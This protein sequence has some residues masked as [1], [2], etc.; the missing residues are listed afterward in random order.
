MSRATFVVLRIK[1]QR[2]V[3]GRHRAVR[4]RT[5]EGE[6]ALTDTDTDS[7]LL[8][9]VQ[10]REL[11]AIDPKLVDWVVT[12]TEEEAKFRRQETKRVNTFVFVEIV[13][14]LLCGLA[15]GIG[16][17]FAAVYVGLNGQ[18]WLGG[19]IA[20]VSLGTLAVAYVLRRKPPASDE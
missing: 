19:G 7:P 8:P 20:S 9:A 15:I 10:L 14:G 13:G 3:M 17:M 12:Q 1:R 5:R 11:Q 2:V 6:L 18:P 4:A 16:G